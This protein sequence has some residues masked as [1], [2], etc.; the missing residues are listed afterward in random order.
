MTHLCDLIQSRFG[1][2]PNSCLINN[3]PNG[4]HYISY[5]SDRDME[6]NEHT[7]VTILSL[8]TVRE[9]AFRN[10]ADPSVKHYY[11]LQPGSA[12]Y[13]D[14]IVQTEWQHGIPKTTTSGTRISLSFRSLIVK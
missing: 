7:G 5:H 12:I 10:M 2:R 13:M 6:M 14:D 4:D 1:Y 9:M 3:Y 8:G 11:A